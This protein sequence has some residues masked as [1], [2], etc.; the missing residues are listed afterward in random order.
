MTLEEIKEYIRE[1][2]EIEFKDDTYA[3]DPAISYKT[4]E[5]TFIISLDENLEKEKLIGHDRW[6]KHNMFGASGAYVVK[7]NNEKEIIDMI[8]EDCFIFKKKKDRQLSLFGGW[9]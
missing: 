8:M 7:N 5:E 3:Y 2:Y 9:L 1:N 6:H 4:R